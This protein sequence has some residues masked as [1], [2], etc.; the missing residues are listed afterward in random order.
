MLSTKRGRILSK[1][2][3]DKYKKG[4]FLKKNKKNEQKLSTK[5]GKFKFKGKNDEKALKNAKKA[6]II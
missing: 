6:K 3:P 1:N 5:W 2:S 4:I